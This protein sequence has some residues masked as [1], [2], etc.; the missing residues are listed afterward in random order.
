MGAGNG[1]GYP[2]PAMNTLQV[3]AGSPRDERPMPPEQAP[4]GTFPGSEGGPGRSSYPGAPMKATMTAQ[5]NGGGLAG[6]NTMEASRT[7]GR[8][9]QG[10]RRPPVWGQRP[11]DFGSQG[12]GQPQVPMQR[13][14]DTMPSPGVRMPPVTQ[15]PQAT[16][17]QGTGNST[18]PGDR[19]AWGAPPQG[20]RMSIPMPPPPKQKED[21]Q[22]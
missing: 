4:G 2:A 17:Y 6:S 14:I 1:W 21:Q 3:G 15:P 11:G 18:V 16:P 20:P 7:W 9:A 22:L 10:L 5:G 19:V 12:Y 13:G 8:Q